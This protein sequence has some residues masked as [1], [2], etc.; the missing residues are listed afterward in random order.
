LIKR[1]DDKKRRASLM[2]AYQQA[3]V[4]LERAVDAGHRFV[5]EDLRVYLG[6]AQT[7]VHALLS[8]VANR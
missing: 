4:P 7:R 3:E 1:I 8:S 5:Y 6:V 2:Q